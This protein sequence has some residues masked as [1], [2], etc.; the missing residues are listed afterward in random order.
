MA[1]I[2]SSAFTAALET[3][4]KT[5]DKQ[6]PREP[7]AYTV[8]EFC[9][10]HRISISTYHKL[11]KQGRGPRIIQP[12]AQARITR[13][14]AAAWREQMEAE[15]SGEAAQLERAR[16]VEAA[17]KAGKKAGESE[18]HVSKKKGK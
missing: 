4:I 13:E 18:L 15:A 16:R 11:R 1:P 8:R 12:G 9:Q 7:D 3:I 5:L 2:E 14:A 17:K 6:P 10:A